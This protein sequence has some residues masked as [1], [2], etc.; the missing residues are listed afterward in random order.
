MREQSPVSAD[1][2]FPAEAPEENGRQRREPTQSKW[3]LR[4]TGVV[5][6]IALL[7]WS[8]LGDAVLSP[9]AH[10]VTGA[11]LLLLVALYMVL[12]GALAGR[13]NVKLE[14]S[15]SEHLERLS[16]SLR[17]LAY[18]DS[19]T[20]LYNHRYFHDHLPSEFERARR[21]GHELSV[22]MLDV[23]HFKEVND[24]YGHLTGDE[25]LSFLGRLIAENVRSSD[26]AARYGGDE[27]ALIL[28][29]T[30]GDSARATAAKIRDVISRRRDWGGG[31]LVDVALDVSAGVAT[32]PDD[33]T[34]A[35]DLLL[36]ADRTLYASKELA[37][38][39][40][41]RRQRLGRMI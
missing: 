27:F 18:H 12:M 26:I 7:A 17:H 29:E 22:V 39:V 20:G 24:R 16:E 32:F 35:E 19:L 30:G 23:N 8:Q 38:P 1:Q 21:Y 33:A 3:L 31:L 5:V 40:H 9:T 14:R 25:V 2:R 34:S 28:P 10:R 36:K 11:A 37:P 13:V 15:Y 4:G 41:R 6:F